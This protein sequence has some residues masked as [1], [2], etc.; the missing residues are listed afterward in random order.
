[1]SEINKPT[2]PLIDISEEAKKKALEKKIVLP[3]PPNRPAA[4]PPR[5][6]VF[7]MEDLMKLFEVSRSTI[8]R[9]ISNARKGIGS[10]PTP[11][12]KVTSEG[13]RLEWNCDAIMEYLNSQN[14]ETPQEP[15]NPM[16]NTMLT[17]T[18][19]DLMQ[20]F[21]KT[22]VTIYRWA[23][24]ARS[25]HGTFPPPLN[26]GGRKRQKLVWSFDTV[27]A[28]EKNQNSGRPQPPLDSVSEVKDCE[29]LE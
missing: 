23:K 7:I 17:L 6:H 13:L 26:T 15:L 4:T 11:E 1:M 5:R 18:V 2:T 24:K 16:N 14:C 8:Q 20:R 21:K 25:G 10:F 27:V 28:F 19:E 12:K 9:W 22:R 29:Q 3:P